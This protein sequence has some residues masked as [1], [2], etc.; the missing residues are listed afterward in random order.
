MQGGHES[1]GRPAREL[2]TV[3]DRANIV[4][5]TA[6]YYDGF[7]HLERSR[8]DRDALI[9]ADLIRMGWLP[10][11]VSAGMLGEPEKLRNRVHSLI[12]SRK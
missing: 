8:R 3:I 6:F 1:C 9:T 10:L 5:R 2:L 12:Q 11:R 7:H 4:H